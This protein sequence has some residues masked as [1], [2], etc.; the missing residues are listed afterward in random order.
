MSL[1]PWD[2]LKPAKCGCAATRGSWGLGELGEIP[3]SV[4]LLQAL[5]DQVA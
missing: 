4:R 5:E 1:A 3:L 2:M